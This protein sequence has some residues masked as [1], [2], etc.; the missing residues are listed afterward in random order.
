MILNLVRIVYHLIDHIVDVFAET[1]L[2]LGRK[3]SATGYIL[4]TQHYL[5]RGA[6]E[7]LRPLLWKTL[8]QMQSNHEDHEYYTEIKEIANQQSV[9]ST[10]GKFLH[11]QI[12]MDCT[13]ASSNDNFFIFE[14]IFPSV[15][16]PFLWDSWVQQHATVHV[17]L[18]ILQGTELTHV[19]YRFL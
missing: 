8:L 9:G 4:S 19:T 18:P 2:A 6:P 1:A 10:I 7:S 16:N 13:S 5:R 12:Q 11:Q 3:V 17:K 15:V 14:D